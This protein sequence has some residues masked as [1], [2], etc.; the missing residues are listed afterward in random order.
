MQPVNQEDDI[1]DTTD[2]NCSSIST[3]GSSSS[4]RSQQ[5]CLTQPSPGGTRLTLRHFRFS[6]DSLLRHQ[7]DVERRLQEDSGEAEDTCSAVASDGPRKA[8]NFGVRYEDDNDSDDW[9]W[10]DGS[11]RS[12]G[13]KSGRRLRTAMAV[14]NLESR[15]LFEETPRRRA[16]HRGGG[17]PQ[18]NTGTGIACAR[19]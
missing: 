2:G 6:D 11:A 8:L 15:I 17:Y 12:L 18:L 5:R 19:S 3:I 10:E 1:T 9:A 13:R 7:C 16:A 14:A 4:G